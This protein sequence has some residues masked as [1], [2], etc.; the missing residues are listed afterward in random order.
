MSRTAQLGITGQLANRL[1]IPLAA[2]VLLT[3]FGV[4]WAMGWHEAYLAIL[5]VIEVKPW[6]F[7]FLDTHALLAAAECQR[8]GFNVYAENPCDV[9]ER[10]HVY[11]PLWLSLIPGFLGT[12][13]TTMVGLVLALLFILT[14][15]FVLRPRSW[16]ETGIYAVA[17]F[18]P[19]TV[20]AVE[21]ANND[22]AMFILIVCA[23]LLW[24]HSFGRRLFAY[25]LFLVAGL[26]KYYPIVLL[27]LAFRERWRRMF[28]VAIC[29]VATLVLLVAAY[30]GEF[31]LALRNIPKSSPFMDTFGAWNLPY[32]LF[33][34]SWGDQVQAPQAAALLLT[35]LL[36]AAAGAI[37]W[38]KYRLLG[39]AAIDWT[40]GE[41][42]NLAIGSILLVACFFAGQSIGYR[43]IYLLLVL[44]GLVLLRQ[45]AI[46][47]ATRRWLGWMI[48]VALG[49]MWNEL[50]R[51]AYDL[52]AGLPTPEFKASPFRIAAWFLMWIGRELLWWWLIAGLMAVVAVFV[53]SLPLV[54]ESLRWVRRWV[55]LAAR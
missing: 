29:S 17:V 46:E 55:P 32:G 51:H 2:L 28:A 22:A 21:R 5:K 41:T 8:H 18:S 38:R 49:L 33:A 50:I 27:G 19:M 40:G 31:A 37:A 7:P 54:D 12:A 1:A 20:F 39:E 9:L 24:G 10:V 45:S 16:R 47:A 26:L 34:A 30:R 13:D 14:L 23:S 36:L 53:R 11:S 25:A 42:R 3:G 6:D 15:G 48:V 4:L 43:G 52:V 44:P 35:G